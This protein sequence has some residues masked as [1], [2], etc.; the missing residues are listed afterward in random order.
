MNY[1]ETEE[2]QRQIKEQYSSR[3]KKFAPVDV[4][5]V[6]HTL[7]IEVGKDDLKPITKG[8]MNATY[9]APALV[10]KINED[11]KTADYAAYVVASSLA[12]KHPIPK[13]LAYDH[14]DKTAYEVLVTTRLS[15]QT[16]I[17]TIFDLDQAAREK[18]FSQMLDVVDGLFTMRFD[19]VG[20]F[21]NPEEKFAT[22]SEYLRH[23]LMQ[24]ADQI[25]RQKTWD[26]SD[27]DKIVAYASKH[28]NVFDDEKECTFVHTDLHMGN[29]LHEGDKLTGL[30]DFDS[31]FRGPRV[32]SLPMILGFVFNPQQYTEGSDYFPKY[33]GQQFLY[34]L[35]ILKARWPAV[36]SDPQ[37]LRKLNLLNIIENLGWVADNWSKEWNKQLIDMFFATEIDKDLKVS[38]F[39]QRL[40]SG[41]YVG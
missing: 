19:S 36:F 16:L 33:K 8:N 40:E 15:G 34:F 10:V 21:R 12:D 3:V 26:A 37:L 7:G 32:A 29:I 38:Y 4:E 23:S 14:F 30:I 35:P 11:K 27:I 13:V 39:G 28:L 5:K 2:Y 41:S 18:L 1:T 9:V 6:L 20:H 31:A 22:Y 24:S 17:D 25:K